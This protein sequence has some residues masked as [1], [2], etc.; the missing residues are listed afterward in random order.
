MGLEKVWNGHSNDM[1]RLERAG[2][3]L[4]KR[5]GMGIQMT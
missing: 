3:G 5:V 2:D 1:K 4:K